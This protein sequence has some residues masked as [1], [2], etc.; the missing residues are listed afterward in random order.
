MLFIENSISSKSKQLW[1]LQQSFRPAQQMSQQ[2]GNPHLSSQPRKALE[3]HTFWFYKL[4][5]TNKSRYRS[6]EVNVFDLR[7]ATLKVIAVL[8][9]DF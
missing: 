6:D 3:S 5:P 1:K 7:S 4:H 9:K 8:F 2:L